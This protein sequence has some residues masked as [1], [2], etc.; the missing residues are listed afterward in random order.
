MENLENSKSI[1]NKLN[2][3]NK[4]Y[5]IFSMKSSQ[6]SNRIKSRKETNTSL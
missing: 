6:F 1:S 2:N 3:H 5:S 4:R